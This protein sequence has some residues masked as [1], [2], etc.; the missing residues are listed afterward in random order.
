MA[1]RVNDLISLIASHEQAGCSS[2]TLTGVG[3]VCL[4]FFFFLVFVCFGFFFGFFSD[5]PC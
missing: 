4:F 3:E 5:R 2:I 1:E